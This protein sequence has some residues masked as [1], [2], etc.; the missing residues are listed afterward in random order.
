MTVDA[1]TAHLARQPGIQKLPSPK[2]TLFVRRGFLEHPSSLRLGCCC[3]PRRRAVLLLISRSVC[4]SDSIDVDVLSVPF[5][6]AWTLDFL[7]YS[8]IHTSVLY[9]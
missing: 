4:K 7:A 3:R 1:I 8:N 5:C 9:L 2:L 6:R